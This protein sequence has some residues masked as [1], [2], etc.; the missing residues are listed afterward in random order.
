MSERDLSRLRRGVEAVAS[1]DG[2]Y[3]V[4]CARTG[5]RPVPVAG[6]RFRSRSHAVVAARL[7][8]RFRAR[9][10]QYDP[11]TVVYDLVVCDVGAGDGKP[12]GR[13]RTLTTASG[14][15]DGE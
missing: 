14:G 9:L 6:R 13:R 15:T 10:R 7:A 3:L 11:K 5:V 4:R 12:A 2:D 1:P 8:S